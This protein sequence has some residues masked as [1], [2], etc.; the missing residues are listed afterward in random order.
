MTKNRNLKHRVRAR[1]AKTGESYTAALRHIRGT[2]PDRA[3]PPLIPRLLRVARQSWLKRDLQLV[4]A[5]EKVSFTATWRAGFPMGVWIVKQD[6]VPVATLRRK[7]LTPLRT[8]SVTMDRYSFLLKN[9][10]SL[11]RRTVVEGGP[12]DGSMLSGDLLD[13]RFRLEH[14]GILIAQA[15][16][17]FLS[18]TDQHSVC[19]VR[20][21]DPAVETFAALMMIDLL[22]QKLDEN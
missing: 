17:K 16:R 11:T 15:E 19:L 14:R 18:M 20:P 13:Q 2:W 6:G 10:L 8:S 4:N 21:I 12:Y 7:M 3:D 9:Q 5:A 22:A 1:A